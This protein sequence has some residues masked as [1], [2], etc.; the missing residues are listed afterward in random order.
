M[1]ASALKFMF[2]LIVTGQGFTYNE[3]GDDWTGTCATGKK[4]SPIDLDDDIITEVTD[5]D[6]IVKTKINL[7]SFK[8][9]FNEYDDEIKSFVYNSN[10]GFGTVTINDIIFYMANIHFHVPSEHTINGDSYDAELHL[11]GMSGDGLKMLEFTVFF[12]KGSESDF[13]KNAIDSVDSSKTLNL[14]TILPN[15]YLEDYYY[16]IGSLSGPIFGDC[17]EGTSWIVVKS[18]QEM[19]SSQLDFFNNRW[20]ND[21]NFA[22]G[23][24]NNRNVQPLNDRKVYYHTTSSTYSLCVAFLLLTA[25]L[26]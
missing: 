1:V 18:P 10:D 4:Q 9:Q 19:S 25:S 11:F 13:V 20:K 21:E 26:I 5:A 12:E 7:A 16:Y 2:A 24:G 17:T 8:G 22:G 6:N 14:T 23:R 3:G 15:G